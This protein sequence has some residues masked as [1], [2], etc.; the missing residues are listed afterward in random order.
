MKP[1]IVKLNNEHWNE[2]INIQDEAYKDVQPE[3]LAVLKSKWLAS[4]ET[5]LVVTLYGE[6]AAYV[7]SHPWG[8]KNPPK[9]FVPLSEN[10]AS[11]KL[12]LHDL[13]VSEKYMRMGLGKF[14]LTHLMKIASDMNF[15]SVSL[16]AVQESQ[17]FWQRFGFKY[18]PEVSVCESYGERAFLMQK[19]L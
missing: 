3:E 16:V 7:L 18:T 11:S 5:C 13:A 14:L 1:K 12:Y 8:H 6:V 15:L 2:I 9:L 19:A 10:V 4:P 17:E